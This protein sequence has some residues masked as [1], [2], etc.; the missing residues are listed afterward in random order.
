MDHVLSLDIAQTVCIPMA[1]VMIDLEEVWKAAP[2]GYPYWPT[3]S[4]TSSDSNTGGFL[5]GYMTAIAFKLGYTHQ[6]L[7][8]MHA[9]WLMARL[10]SQ[11]GTSLRSSTRRSTAISCANADNSLYQPTPLILT[12][13]GPINHHNACK[14]HQNQGIRH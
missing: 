8:A 7:N 3:W 4:G 5:I 14:P 11:N 2:K 1:I 13:H 9:K 6:Q 12:R 10:R